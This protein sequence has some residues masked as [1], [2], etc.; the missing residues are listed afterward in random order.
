MATEFVIALL[1][2]VV[3]VVVS[4]S[5]VVYSEL[6]YSEVEDSQVVDV[7]LQLIMVPR[8]SGVEYLMPLVSAAQAKSYAS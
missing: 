1:E 6:A 2:S 7:G 5:I 8:Q 4:L 3:V